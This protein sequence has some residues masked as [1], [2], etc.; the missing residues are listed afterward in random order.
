MPEN[1]LPDQKNSPDFVKLA[2][3]LTI[4]L[5]CAVL[6]ALFLRPVF[7]VLVMAFALAV[8][9]RPVFKKLA[10]IIKNDSVAAACT[11]LVIVLGVVAPCIWIAASLGGE[12]SGAYRQASAFLSEAGR[13][14]ELMASPV[15]SR[16]IDWASN[17][18]LL[19]DPAEKIMSFLVNYGPGIFANTT[20]FFLDLLLFCAV[21]FYFLKDGGEFFAKI[22]ALSPLDS[23]ANTKLTQGLKGAA[24]AVISGSLVIM[25]LQGFVAGVGY[26]IFGVPSPALLGALTFLATLV[27]VIGAAIIV[28]PIVIIILIKGA[29][30]KA[31]G[32]ALWAAILHGAI[33]NFLKPRVIDMGLHAHPLLTMFAMLGGLHEL[34]FAGIVVGPLVLEIAVTLIGIYEAGQVK[35][36]QTIIAAG[37]ETPAATPP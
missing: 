5:F 37:A 35:D 4:F 10:K 29:V 14:K 36:S 23:A 21:L 22:V 32:L 26:W 31:V 28:A 18:S 6:L 3:L 7:T 25:A 34:G 15:V 17:T 30:A 8:A 20:K 1:A 27:P 11:T 9:S 16:A 33:D 13:Q 19:S 12:I 2:F 24:N